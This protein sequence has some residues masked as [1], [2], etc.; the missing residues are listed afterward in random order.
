MFE[1]VR[2]VEVAE[3]TRL[4]MDELQIAALAFMALVYAYKVYWILKRKPVKERTPS[5]GDEGR[6][7]RYAYM[8]IAMPWEVESQ[9]RSPLRWIE[10][11]MFHVGVAVAIGATFVLPYAPWVLSH[12]LTI[13]ILQGI[14][15][16]ALL[17]GIS[18]LVRRIA[19]AHMRAISSPDDYFSIVLLDA[20]LASAIWGVMQTSE[21]GLLVYFGMTAFFLVTVPFTKIS[22]YIFWPFIRFYTGKHFGH[23]GVFPRKVVREGMA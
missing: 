21:T 8:T 4:V 6:A 2:M 9:R 13:L 16:L 10:F 3:V 17:G 14:L 11:A 5:R 18:R 19:R 1:T 23:R 12:R 15:G 20:W 7:I 22:H